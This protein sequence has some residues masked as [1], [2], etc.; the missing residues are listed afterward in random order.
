MAKKLVGWIEPSFFVLRLRTAREWAWRFA[1]V[2]GIA[3][4]AFVLITMFG[5]GVRN[6]LLDVQISLVIGA[7]LTFVID[8][9]YW[10]RDITITDSAIEWEANAGKFA[11]RGAH[12]FAEIVRVDCQRPG[13]WKFAYGGLLITM[14]N[15]EIF[16]VGVPKSKNLETIATILFRQGFTVNLS[17]WVPTT[18]DTRTRVEDELVLGSGD[19][20]T[21]DAVFEVL[22]P[23]EPR[24]VPTNGR[25][26][27]ALIGVAPL[28]LALVGM[29]G[30]WVYLGMY[31]GQLTVPQRALIGVGGVGGFVLGFIYIMIVGQHIESALLLSMGHK[32]LRT[33]LNP[34]V[35]L[36]G[37]DLFPVSV[38]P[39]ENWTK[40]ATLSP[41]FG[42]LQVDQRK[43]AVVFE[44]NKE[45]W[46]IPITALTAIRIEEAQ[47]GKEGEPS[48]EIRYFVVLSTHRDGQPWDVG[49]TRTRTEWGFDGQ[50]AR[51]QR[52][53]T[54][55]D[56]L[57]A[58]IGQV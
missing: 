31:W 6:W 40:V 50:Q 20:L 37:V 49:L 11:F 25:V 43:S 34:V 58:S 57:R 1:W 14:T 39:R 51:R 54:L 36:D 26:V 48:S 23:E 15:G 47:V 44:G 21:K 24:L 55:F 2:A 29:I 28:L 46:T 10:H 41:D 3:L 4:T 7:I 42:F 9:A 16:A 32:N 18:A 12:P 38:S 8:L 52:M 19:K 30:T 45:R 35:D 27:A 33:R 13:E 56:D 5:R 53:G 22:P 17:G